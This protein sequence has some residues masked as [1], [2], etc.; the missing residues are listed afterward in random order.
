MQAEQ[1]PECPL[2]YS[3]GGFRYCDLLLAGTER[4]AGGGPED[5]GSGEASEEAER[6][7]VQALQWQEGMPGAPLLDFALHHLTLGRARLRRAIIAGSAP[8]AA[9]PEIDQGVDGLRRAGQFDELPKGLLTR[10]WLR[11]TQNRPDAAR[12][13][14]AE[15]EEIAERGPMPLF[16]ADVHLFRARLFHDRAALAEA[17]RL[18]EKHGYFR[19][20]EELEDLE[21]AADRR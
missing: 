9:E 6:R 19:R 7:A 18:V 1:Q 15:A 21:A 14:L 8:D 3:M 12:A 11:C 20:R 10:A 5:R 13:D 17:K 16:L 4:A 2:L